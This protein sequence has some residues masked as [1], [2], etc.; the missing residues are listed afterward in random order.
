MF[1]FILPALAGLFGSAAG[2]ASRSRENQNQQINQANRNTIDLYGTQQNAVSQQAQAQQAALMQALMGQSNE[3]INQGNLDLNR[4]QFALQAPGVRGKQALLGSLLERMQP[5]SFSG[6]SPRL[7]SRMP[8]ISGGLSPAAL[9]PHARQAGQL[10]QAGAVRGL[11]QGETF[12][13]LQRTDFRSGVLDPTRALL[14]TPTL[15]GMQSPGLL[16]KLLGGGALGTGLLA[17]ILQGRS[18]GTGM[19]AETDYRAGS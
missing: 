18:Q 7:Q 6:L 9:G 15:Q 19:G 4:R 8:Q 11:Q 10:M 3:Q 16:E 13:P 5:V 1:Q 14:P 17:A 2:G 12:D